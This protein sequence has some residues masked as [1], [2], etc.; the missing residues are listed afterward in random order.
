LVEVNGILATIVGDDAGDDAGDLP[1]ISPQEIDRAEK[2][3][4]LYVSGSREE[5]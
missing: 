3:D 5:D 1:V 4:N 2:V